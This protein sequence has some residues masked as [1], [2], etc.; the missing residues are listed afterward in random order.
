MSDIS[1]KSM[2]KY[3]KSKGIRIKTIAECLEIPYDSL[4]N[5]MKY[6]R[7]LRAD[8]FMAMCVFFEKNPFDFYPRIVKHSEQKTPQFEL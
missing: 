5:S 4:Y 3:I 6:K 8:E 2:S 1:T 7:P